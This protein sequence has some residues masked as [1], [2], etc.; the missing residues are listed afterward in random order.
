MTAAV[1]DRVEGWRRRYRDRV[2]A[3]DERQRRLL[4]AASFL[5][6]FTVLAAPL[7]AV[8]WLG[9]DGT[10]MRGW[11]AEAVMHVLRAVGL[12]AVRDGTAVTVPGLVV[13]VSRD[14]TGW[15]SVFAVAALVAAVKRPWR[16][17]LAGVM[18]GVTA[19]LVMNVVRVASMVYAVSVWQVEYA[20]L[21]TVLWRWGLTAV[22]V[23]VWVAWLRLWPRTA[24]QFL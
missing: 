12:D 18:L 24:R 21:H 17:R 19:V 1:Q 14:S 20:L 23:G 9:W 7:Y 8:V 6:R 2:S 3:L 11:T 15:K 22:V 13:D 4:A 10:P 5:V 16:S